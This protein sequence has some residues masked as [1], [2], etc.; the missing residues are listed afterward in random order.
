MA[1]RHHYVPRTY[2]GRFSDPEGFLR[3]FRKDPP[4][5]P[6]RQK[7][8]ATGFERYYYSHIRE[9]G[10]RDDDRFERL[11]SEVETDWPDIVVNLQARRTEFEKASQLI[12]F[13]GLMRVRGP[14]FRDTIEL[15][16]GDVSLAQ[17]KSL[18]A[19]GRLPPPPEGFENLIDNVRVAIDPQ[20][21]LEAMA[22]ILPDIGQLL[23][24]LSWD[25]LHN[26][27]D[28][29][30]ITSDNP[31]IYYDPKVTSA[32]RF[33]YTIRPGG[34]VEALFPVTPR[35][36]L[37]GRRSPIRPLIGHRTLL[38]PRRVRSYNRTIARYGYRVV[39]ASSDAEDRTIKANLAVSPVARFDK[40]PG[41]NGSQY[42][43]AQ[44]VFGPRETKPKW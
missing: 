23:G 6:F 8:E 10:T 7:P 2:L 42:G 21:S 24:S 28:V 15:S 41:P 1:K 13:L 35:M 20:Q 31:M 17:L 22:R 27:T 11:F 37:R 30:F 33:P 16:M 12:V 9:D 36:L 5:G 29:P 32:R 38:E 40:V 14:A 19:A 18:D 3:V 4:H 44:M 34:P 25:V 26:V 39:F 43:I